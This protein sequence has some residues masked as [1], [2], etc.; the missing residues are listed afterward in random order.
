MFTLAQFPL[1]QNKKLAGRRYNPL[2]QDNFIQSGQEFPLKEAVVKLHQ[3]KLHQV[4][5][6]HSLDVV[7]PDSHQDSLF[8]KAARLLPASHQLT[9]RYNYGHL[10]LNPIS[11]ISLLFHSVWDSHF[12]CSH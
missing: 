5:S 3:C 7:C 1:H 9:G 10:G 4:T 12:W 11:P 2:T 8:L 6:A